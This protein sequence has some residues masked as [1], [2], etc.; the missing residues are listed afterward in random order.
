MYIRI[1]HYIYACNWIFYMSR[2]YITDTNKS[3]LYTLSTEVRS[4]LLD[5]LIA[6]SAE[7]VCFSQLA[8]W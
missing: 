3:T 8:T 2:I 7:S 5:T 4:S 1:A 6:A